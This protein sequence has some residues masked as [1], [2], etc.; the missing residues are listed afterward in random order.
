MRTTNFNELR[1]MIIKESIDYLRDYCDQDEYFDPEGNPKRILIE[2][3]AP[4][5]AYLKDSP[6]VLYYLSDYDELDVSVDIPDTM[7]CPF[8]TIRIDTPTDEY[9][10]IEVHFE[11]DYIGY[12]MCEPDDYGYDDKHKCCGIACD[13]EVPSIRVVKG[14]RMD[15][16]RFEGTQKDLWR[17]E[18]DFMIE[19]I[20]DA[21]RIELLKQIEQA[22]ES[23][24]YH[25][26]MHDEA[27]NHLAEL[28]D[29]LDKLDGGEC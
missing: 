23:I 20:D 29:Q 8:M 11:P 19:F 9:Y 14:S 6:T 3:L 1:K 5:N 2:S 28:L 26:S 21:N 18:D 24:D 22:R 16:S 7:G 15:S 12:C 17:V 4:V 10:L 25:Q 13:W 27:S